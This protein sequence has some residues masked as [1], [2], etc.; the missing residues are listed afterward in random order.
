MTL[1]IVANVVAL[2]DGLQQFAPDVT[3]LA[4]V[5]EV[6]IEKVFEGLWTRAH[7]NCRHHQLTLTGFL[8]QLYCELPFLCT[9]AMRSVTGEQVNTSVRN[10]CTM[11]P[12]MYMYVTIFYI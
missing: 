5:H 10:R 1:I 9:P 8:V 6:Q 3:M 7:A 2:T 4:G 11:Q 12:C